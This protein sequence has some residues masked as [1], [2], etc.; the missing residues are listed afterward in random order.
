MTG[1]CDRQKEHMVNE[2][3][4]QKLVIVEDSDTRNE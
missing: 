2:T 3:G 1:D 4:K